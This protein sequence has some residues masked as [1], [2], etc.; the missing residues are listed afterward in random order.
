M[1]LSSGTVT[2]VL[3][4]IWGYCLIHLEDTPNIIG[5]KQKFNQQSLT[6]TMLVSKLNSRQWHWILAYHKNQVRVLNK[7]N[8]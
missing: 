6:N 7:G 4:G 3:Y 8:V 2:F 5:K 1:T